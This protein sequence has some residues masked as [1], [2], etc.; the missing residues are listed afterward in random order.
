MM[1][2]ASS[3]PV[4]DTPHSRAGRLSAGDRRGTVRASRRREATCET[5]PD[6][7]GDGEAMNH[8]RIQIS[9]GVGPAEVR[10]FVALLASRL[11]ALCEER[12]LAASEVLSRGDA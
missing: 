2:R 8:Y 6:A 5:G 12:G 4:H 3:T 11:E 9:A 7:R 1:R 10:R